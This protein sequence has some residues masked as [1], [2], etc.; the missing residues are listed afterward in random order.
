MVELQLQEPVVRNVARVLS[1]EKGGAPEP[2][3][4]RW[5]YPVF[6]ATFCVFLFFFGINTGD[7]W[8]TENLRA[9]IAQ[10]FL[11]SGDWIVPRL[12]GE[13][14]LT[15]PPGMYA[16]IAL[17]SWPLGEVRTWSAR[18]PSALAATV[19][20]FLFYWYFARIFG[21]MA[22]LLAAVILPTSPMWLDKASVA[23]ID[24]LQVAW[25]TAALLFF[26]RA[27]ECV[28]GSGQSKRR[29]AWG[30]WLGALL[31]VAGGVLTKW[32]AATFFYFTVIPLL[33]WR[34]RL[35]LLVSR[36]H[37]VCATVAASLVLAWA[38]MAIAEAG[39]DTFSYRIGREAVA[40]FYPQKYGDV[41]RWGLVPLHPFRLLATTLPWSAV[42]L[43]TLR[44]G[45]GTLWDE[46]GRRL[47]QALHCWV[48]PNMLFW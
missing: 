1:Q 23:E 30:W 46:R 48:W 38:G 3:T 24:M 45:F 20:V 36:Q 21:R 26:L 2:A 41:Y 5:V 35:G 42:V 12:Y 47:L 40:R 10:E 37:L 4:R 27:L 43:L 33:W 32:T 9:L 15:K 13:P 29:S 17:A 31:C 14:Y 22:G 6:L 7:L 28:E 16:A 8:R 19:C 25:V 34:G 44:P 18:L 39:W 11:R